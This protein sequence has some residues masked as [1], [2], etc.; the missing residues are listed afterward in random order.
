VQVICPVCAARQQRVVKRY[1]R[2]KGLRHHLDRV[3]QTER[4]AYVRM[5]VAIDLPK[6]SNHQTADPN[7]L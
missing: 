7:Q 2:G 4:D 6:L 5:C 3:H 1:N